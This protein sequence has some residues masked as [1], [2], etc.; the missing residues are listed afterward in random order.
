MMPNRKQ[1]FLNTLKITIAT[2]VLGL[3]AGYLAGRAIT[4]EIFEDRLQNYAA[5]ILADGAASSAELRTVLAAV[6]TSPHPFCSDA[7]I[8]YLRALIFESEY[9]KDVGRMRDGKIVCSATLGRVTKAFAQA[10]PDF[11]QQDGS[12]IYQ[13]SVP[14]QESDHAA[15]ALQ[16][17]DSYVV[18]TP[19]T[20]LHVEPAPMHFTET[21]MNAPTHKFGRLD[22]ES[23]EAN[24][25]VLTTEGQGRYGPNLYATSCS[26]RYFNCVTA[27]MSVSEALEADHTHFAICVALGGLVGVCLGLVGSLLYR[28]NRGMEQQLRRAIHRDNLRV[29]YQPI[30]NLANRRI[31]GAEALVRWTDEEG[32]AIGPDVFVRLAEKRGFVGEITRLVLRHVLRDFGETLRKQPGF[33][34]SINVAAADLSDPSFLPELEQALAR[35]GVQ[36]RSLA[37]EITESS[38]VQHEMAKESIR[39]L[40]QRGH[41]VHIDDFGTGYSS[42]SYLHDLSV[43][44]IKIDRAFTQAIGTGSVVVA[45]LPQILAMAAALKLQVIVEGVETSGQ[46]SYFSSTEQPIL[47]QGWLFGRPIPVGQFRDLLAGDEL[48]VLEPAETA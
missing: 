21:V 26:T 11:T 15:I 47:A 43:D 36:P 22:G 42:L 3:V 45:I 34:L 23:F 46:A 37:I 1:R 31:T 40:R 7:E 29:V 44:A 30:V 13:S 35:A 39:C 12:V 32:D 19:L 20:R 38:T 4:L 24:G 28:R 17:G 27:Y 9:P 48:K 33:R 14:Y 18:F 8:V 5:R 25:T 2:A 16:L 10:R 41:S 6:S